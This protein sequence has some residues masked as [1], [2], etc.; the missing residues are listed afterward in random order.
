MPDWLL[1]LLLLIPVGLL[2][3]M[4]LGFAKKDMIRRHEAG[5]NNFI[6]MAIVLIPVAGPL[7]YLL[8]RRWLVPR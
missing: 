1:L 7:L 4:V 3:A 5:R 8:V 2:Y 6:V